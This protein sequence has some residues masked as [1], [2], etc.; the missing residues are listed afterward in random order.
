MIYETKGIHCHAYNKTLGYELY[1]RKSSDDEWKTK[2][3][4]PE[5]SSHTF[6]DLQCGT[7]YRIYIVAYN[8]VGKSKNGPILVTRTK[9]NK[10][11]L[12]RVKEIIVA[13]ATSLLLNLSKWPNG[14]CK[15]SHYSVMYKVLGYFK[16]TFVSNSIS[17]DK[18]VV[19]D[20][21]PATWYEIRA[22]AENS[23]GVNE[24]VFTFATT[25][26]SGGNCE[27]C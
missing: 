22:K 16:W 7:E 4:S 27:I 8:K 11:D 18:L 12:P 23:A 21:N 15:I 26:R 19:H 17:S 6:E 13:N 5:H 2:E 10:P 20:L 3:I 14:G 25:T 1:F 9:G 24:G